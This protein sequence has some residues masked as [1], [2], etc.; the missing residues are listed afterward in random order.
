MFGAFGAE[1]RRVD[2]G[3]EDSMLLI[4]TIPSNP[5]R[6]RDPVAIDES[7]DSSS[8]GGVDIESDPRVL[9]EFEGKDG[10]RVERVRTGRKQFR[11]SRRWRQVLTGADTA[12]GATDFP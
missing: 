9:P 5:V 7:A 3:R 6:S 1:H 8:I 12:G 2:P 11:G 10:G 4:E